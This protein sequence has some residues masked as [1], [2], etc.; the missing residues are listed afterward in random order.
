MDMEHCQGS[1]GE[2]HYSHGKLITCVEIIDDYLISKYRGQ[3]HTIDMDGFLDGC[4]DLEEIIRRIYQKPAHLK[5]MKNAGFIIH[6]KVANNTI[7]LV[8]PDKLT[9]SNV[10][11]LEKSFTKFET[12]RG[13]MDIKRLPGSCTEAL[14]IKSEDYPSFS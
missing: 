13:G 14:S 6:E 12:S 2:E 7:V 4:C 5:G 1:L 3:S 10:L 9:E 8:H 11:A